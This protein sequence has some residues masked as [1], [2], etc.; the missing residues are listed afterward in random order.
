M[1]DSN[2][3]DCA[4]SF[5]GSLRIE[6]RPEKLTCHAGLVMLRELDERLALTTDLAARLVDERAPDRIQHSLSQLLRTSTYATDRRDEKASPLVGV[7]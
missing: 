5:N 1:G 4:P 3:T 6:G 2:S 7:P